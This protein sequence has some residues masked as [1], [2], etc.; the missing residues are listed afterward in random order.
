MSLNTKRAETDNAPT[1]DWVADIH[2]MH[3]KFGVREVVEN[4]DNEK[5]RKFL[6]FRLKFLQ[7][8]LN[9]AVEAFDTKDPSRAEDVVDAMIDLCVV[10]IGT[11]D[12]FKVDAHD[13]WQ[14]VLDANMSKE[15]GIKEGRQNPLGLPDLCKPPGWE[16]PT[17]K[18][19]V[20]LIA[21]ALSA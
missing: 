2:A 16:A 9:E 5:L 18:H 14:R 12:A 4:F 13:G 1:T 8:E 21:R 6:E 11:L 17:H 15:V 19:N 3:T 7:E 20:G 10:A